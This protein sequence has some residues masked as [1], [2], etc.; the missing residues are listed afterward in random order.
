MK[1]I[2]DLLKENKIDFRKNVSIAEYTS[3]KVGGLAKFLVIC[4]KEKEL[5]DIFRLVKK[6]NIDCLIIGGGSNLLVSDNGLD[7]IVIVNRVSKIL[8]SG[9]KINVKSGTL[10][11]DLVSFSINNNLLGI[12]RLAGIPGSVGGA[13]YGNAG[14]YGKSISDTLLSVKVF[15]GNKIYWVDKKDLYFSYRDSSFKKGIGLILEAE[16]LL[17]KEEE[18]VVKNIFAKTLKDRQKKYEKGIYCPGSFFKN[19]EAKNLPRKILNII[20]KEKIV[21]GKV[22]A[23][24]LLESVD[25]KGLK[26]GNIEVS[27]KHANFFINKGNGKAQDFYKLAMILKKRVQDKFGIVLEPEVQVIGFNK[28]KD[29][30]NKRIAVVG[31]GLEGKD[32]VRYLKKFNKDITVFDR[33]DKKELKIDDEFKDINFILGSKYSLGLLNQF[34]VIYRSPGVYRFIKEITDAEKKG[35]KVS[36][37]TD[38]FFQKC[39]G[40]IIAVT[41]TKGKGTTSTL[42]YN[43]LKRDG[44]KVFL[45]GNIG[46]PYLEILDLIDNQSWVVMEISSFQLIDLKVS[47]HIAAVLN[48]TQDHLDWHKDLKEYINAKKNIVLFQKKEDFCVINSDYEVLDSF[49]KITKSKTYFT[50]IKEEVNG[51]FVKDNK[52]I[53]KIDNK[54][55]EIGDTKNLLLRGTHNW[56]N[57]TAAILSSFL[58]NADIQSIKDEI[59]SFKGLEH[60]LELVKEINGVTFYNDSFATGPQPTIAAIK[61]F[62]EPIT[63]IL[64]GYDKKLSYDDLIGTIL[65]VKNL[66]NIILI[67][68]LENKLFELLSKSGYKGN[69]FR[70]GKSKMKEIINKAYKVTEKGG[71]VI[72]SPA[73]ASFDMFENYKQRGIHF[74]KS[75]SKLK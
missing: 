48:I 14:A 66:K 50:S 11:L 20:P 35:V 33:K 72:L 5:I 52:I 63:L 8:F 57:I 36:S 71:V 61:S 32:L 37:A 73:A 60:R 58:A 46:K 24:Y 74:K 75:V 62:K 67:G 18:K 43:I 9:E 29:K 45:V 31:F 70:L 15:D 53:L 59:F 16:F 3:T 54:T 44:K 1:N 51:C 28:N 2:E 38:V 30:K 49:S 19:L 39:K 17:K 47:P 21:Y 22:P 55:E 56:E 4:K 42:I 27:E 13:I 68:D 40:K 23:G 7:G 41:G 34:D 12:E 6:N 65:L 26:V 64:G 69:L 10:L 25:A